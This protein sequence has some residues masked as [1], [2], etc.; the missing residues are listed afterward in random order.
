MSPHECAQTLIAQKSG[1]YRDTL[2]LSVTLA[3]G[4]IGVSSSRPWI[5]LIALSLFCCRAREDLIAV[6]A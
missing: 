2:L 6:E 1:R 3:L 5:R 4:C